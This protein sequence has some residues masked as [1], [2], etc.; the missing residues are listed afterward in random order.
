MVLLWMDGSAPSVRTSLP[1][2]HI[3]RLCLILTA[4]D[5][6]SGNDPNFDSYRPSRRRGDE[7]EFSRSVHLKP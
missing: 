5:A 7:P 3:S 2:L 4:Q 1:T 6:A